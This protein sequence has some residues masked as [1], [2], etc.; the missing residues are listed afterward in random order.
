MHGD[1]RSTGARQ[2]WKEHLSPKVHAG[3]VWVTCHRCGHTWAYRGSKVAAVEQRGERKGLW[4]SC[5]CGT[6]QITSVWGSKS[7]V[8]ELAISSAS[9]GG[10]SPGP[11][12]ETEYYPLFR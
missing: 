4:V 3:A 8:R 11:L 6:P 10:I 1:R 12:T 5:R 9:L 2:R 7:Y